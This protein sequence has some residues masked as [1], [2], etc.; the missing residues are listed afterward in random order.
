MRAA[1]KKHY[2][3]MRWFDHFFPGLRAQRALEQETMPLTISPA[4]EP[5]T[6][7]TTSEAAKIPAVHRALSII[8]TAVMQLSLDVERYGT[9]LTD[10]EIPSIIRKPNLDTTRSEL[11]EQ[12]TLSL[13]TTG[14]AYLLKETVGIEVNQLHVLNPHYMSV[15]K[16]AANRIR[17]GYETTEY[18]TADIHHIKL[19]SMPGNLYGVGP[20]QA[21]QGTMQ[22][23]RD[24]RDYS[25]SWFDTGTP[26]GVLSSDDK[27]TSEE[28]RTYRRYWNNLDENGQPIT[29]TE[30]PSRI[31]VLGRGLTYMPIAISPK[32]A[33]WIEAQ[34]FTTLEIARIFGVP[35]T[36]MLTAADGNSMTYANVEQEWIGFVRFGLMAY[37]RRIE[38]ALTALTPRGQTVRFNIE[39]LLRS[40][41]QSRYQAHKTGIEAGFLTINEVR[42]IEN[43]PPLTQGQLTHQ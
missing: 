17:Y 31:K 13:A 30:N 42:A 3:Y 37:L 7:V 4:R 15:Y 40:D 43:L 39:T 41:T 29:S 12:I 14:N 23:A 2:G 21:A 5:L 20:I 36:L 26:S 8:T 9:K 27:L 34:Q 28:A 18:T 24:M 35:A 6:H 38:E 32:D 33:Q 10:K 1:S 16:D 11:L 22:A 19:L 25:A